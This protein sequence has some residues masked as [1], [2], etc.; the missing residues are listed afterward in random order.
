MLHSNFSVQYWGKIFGDVKVEENCHHFKFKL[1]VSLTCQ[2]HTT[3]PKSHSIT[4]IELQKF[5][6]SV[7]NSIVF[8]VKQIHLKSG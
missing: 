4:G 2:H 3:V 5:C 8:S 7:N 1:P 6:D